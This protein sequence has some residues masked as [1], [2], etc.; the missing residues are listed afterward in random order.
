MEKKNSLPHTKT[1]YRWTKDLKR[2]KRKSKVKCKVL[3][4][5]EENIERYFGDLGVGRYFL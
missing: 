3:K 2:K 4:L 5:L 1:K